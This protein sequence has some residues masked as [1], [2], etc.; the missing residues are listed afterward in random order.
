MLGQRVVGE[1]HEY[2]PYVEG[3]GESIGKRMVWKGGFPHL[4]T[5]AEIIGGVVKFK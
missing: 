2:P 1:G 4:E 5:K 3:E